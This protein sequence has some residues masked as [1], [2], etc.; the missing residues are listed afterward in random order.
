VTRKSYSESSDGRFQ[1]EMLFD[2]FVSNLLQPADAT[3]TGPFRNGGYLATT[4][5]GYELRVSS[6]STPGKVTKYNIEHI[7]TKFLYADY[8]FFF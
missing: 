6:E 4:L 2:C 7:S 8:I 1:I 5:G 3:T